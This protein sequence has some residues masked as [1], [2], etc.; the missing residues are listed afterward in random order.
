VIGL[1]DALDYARTH[2]RCVLITL[3]ADGRPQ[4]SNVFAVVG[5]DGVLRISLTDGRAKTV[6]LRRDPRVSLHMVAE[7]FWSY[8][9]LEGEADLSP[10]AADPHDDTV[11]ELVAYYRAGSGE[12]PD[13][14]E[15]R[16]TMVADR[17]LVLRVRP[18]Y[19]YGMPPG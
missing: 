4:S 8:V 5:D 2:P 6:N 18:T 14:D 16:A 17:R 10:V 13:W 19:A 1:D 3:K 15:F 11:E 7:D 9:V 12:H